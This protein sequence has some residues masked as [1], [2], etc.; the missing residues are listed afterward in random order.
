MGLRPCTFSVELFS[1]YLFRRKSLN[2]INQF[3]N[4]RISEISCE[5]CWKAV[6]RRLKDFPHRIIW[7]LPFQSSLSNKQRIMMYKNI[8]RGRRCFILANGPS[9]N[10]T[11]LSLLE[12]EITI[13]MNRIYLME[14]VN[15]F[16]PDYLVVADI[17][18]QL[19]QFT[20]EYNDVKRPRFYNWNTRKLF[21]KSEN[22]MFF[23][24]SFSPLFQPDF[25]KRIGAGKSVTFTCFQLAYYMGFSEVFLIGKDHS[26]NISGIPHMSVESKGD[27][28]NHFVKE[29]YKK[30]MKWDI[31][32]YVGEEYSYKLAR[33][34]FE[35]NGRKIFDATINGKL[36]VFEKID[37]NGLFANRK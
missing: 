3:K 24:E 37:Y 13:G 29:Y 14:G 36:N 6:V 20:N 7:K 34:A 9:L 2:I 26:Y 15:G 18:I 25:T 16:V 27:E 32:D 21:D 4:K 23:K 35:N 22:L 31:P 12:N 30:G 17:D 10:K 1:A 5:R 19:W 8:H 28:T 33:E 11:D